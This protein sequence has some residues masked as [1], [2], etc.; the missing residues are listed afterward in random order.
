MLLYPSLI[1]RQP[2][3]IRNGFHAQANAALLVH[4]QHFHLDKVAFAEF[5]ADALHAFF[6]DLGDVYQAVASGQDG[7]EGAKVHQPG[8][9][10]LID[11]ADLDVGGDQADA[12]LGLLPGG[13]LHRNPDES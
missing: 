8:H 7:D 11:S 9:F 10:A 6:G 12:L 4:L 13:F 1:R 5:V 2:L 3:I